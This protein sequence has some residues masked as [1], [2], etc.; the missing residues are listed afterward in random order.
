M[1]EYSQYNPGTQTCERLI[2]HK[3][4]YFQMIKWLRKRN[5]KIE[6]SEAL[7]DCIYD[8]FLFIPNLCCSEF[9]AEIIKNNFL[10]AIL[11]SVILFPLPI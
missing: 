2:H 5:A 1:K 6:Y 7:F 4:L 8:I 3:T 10:I 9:S 11:N